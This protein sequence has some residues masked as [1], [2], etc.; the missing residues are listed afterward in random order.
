[1]F[2][3]PRYVAGIGVAV[4]LAAIPAGYGDWGLSAATFAS[5]LTVVALVA[6]AWKRQAKLA[7]L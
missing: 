2:K 6:W 7:A 3:K 5:G 1:M 4:M